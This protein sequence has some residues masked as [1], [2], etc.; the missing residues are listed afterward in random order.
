[1]D[2]LKGGICIYIYILLP[3][4]GMI[5]YPTPNARKFGTSSSSLTQ[6]YLAVGNMC[7]VSQEG[8]SNPI[9]SMG[10]VV[11]IYTFT[12]MGPIKSTIHV[13]KYYRSSHGSLW[14]QISRASTSHTLADSMT[15]G[16][17]WC[18]WQTSVPTDVQMIALQQL[19]TA[20]RCLKDDMV[21][22]FRMVT[23]PPRKLTWLA[24]KSPDSE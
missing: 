8:I 2:P 9:G 5:R 17:F 18:I 4:R 7:W 23:L 6:T 19:A 22:D 21:K 12:I 14:E 24:G 10:L 15:W 16:G 1:M 3:S 13:G 20:L 11:F